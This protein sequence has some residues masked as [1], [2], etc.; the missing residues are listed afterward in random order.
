MTGELYEQYLNAGFRRSGQIVY[1]PACEN[2]RECQPLRVPVSEFQPDRSMRRC[3]R[4][5]QDLVT[6]IGLPRLTP[7]KLDLYRRYLITRHDEE[8]PSGPEDFL[9]LSAVES[10]EVEFRL[11]EELVAVAIVDVVPSGLSAVYTYFAPEH[12]SRG[13]GAFAVL[14]EIDYCRR[15]GKP[16]VYLGYYVRDCRKMNYKTR[17][18]PHEIL[19]P[20]GVWQR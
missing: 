7:A 13:L 2:C 4:A 12:A 16:Y 8:D 5:N 11:G 18:A 3:W 6:H 17:F 1:R 14:W 10:L 9:Y 20:D 15:Q 19:A